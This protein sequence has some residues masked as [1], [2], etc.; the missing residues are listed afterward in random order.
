MLSIYDAL[1]MSPEMRQS[2]I[3]ILLEPETFKVAQE[4]LQ[5]PLPESEVISI[6]FSE[7]LKT[8]D[9]NR[10]LYVTATI[11]GNLLNRILVDPGSSV[12][13]VTTRTLDILSL[14]SKKLCSD[15]FML[16][17]FNEKGQKTLGSIT[18]LGTFKT[19]V[20]VIDANTSFRA[21]LG[22][23]WIHEYG[24]VPSTLHQCIKDTRNG[25]EY[26]IPG[27]LHPFTINEIGL[28][29]DAELFVSKKKPV[30]TAYHHVS[31]I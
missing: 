1:M 10:P 26:S 2:L 12:N 9:H 15:R 3:Q 30:T 24:M 11:Y 27:D 31:I 25:E 5:Q 8:T 13:V 4:K 16:H 22:R 29:D 18:L 14:S 7:E 28:Y 20:H 17:G 23:P 6:S 21:L 19:E